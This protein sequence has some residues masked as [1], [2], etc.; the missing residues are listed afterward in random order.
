MSQSIEL[1]G[2]PMAFYQY[3]NTPAYSNGNH[4]FIILDGYMREREGGLNQTM[5]SPTIKLR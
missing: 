2:L 1:I 3:C 4:N 5:M